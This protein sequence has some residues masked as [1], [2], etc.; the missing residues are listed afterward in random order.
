MVVIRYSVCAELHRFFNF[1][2]TNDPSWVAF[3]TQ[4][5]T[6]P[7]IGRDRFSLISA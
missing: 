1:Y 3:L 7:H 2:G 4:G 6:D 5:L